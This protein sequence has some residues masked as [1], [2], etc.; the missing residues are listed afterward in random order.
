MANWIVGER[1]AAILY[2]ISYAA[3]TER[4]VNSTDRIS[5]KEARVHFKLA[6][7]TNTTCGN[8]KL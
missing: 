4:G 2:V 8:L 1:K 7:H 6:E 5:T 3:F